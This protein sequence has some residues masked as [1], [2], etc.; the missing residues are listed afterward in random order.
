MR[1]FIYGFGAVGDFPQGGVFP[2]IG[3]T[4]KHPSP[5]RGCEM[6]AARFGA[7]AK[8][9]GLA[10]IDNLWSDAVG[11]VSKGW[12]SLPGRIRSAT[13]AP[14]MGGRRINAALRFAVAQ[15]GKI[16]ACDDFKY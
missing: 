13:G 7:T 2:P 1:Q 3:R 6:A 4:S 16:R 8:A 12:P 11:Q 14:T 10:Y 9:S 15:M 5:R